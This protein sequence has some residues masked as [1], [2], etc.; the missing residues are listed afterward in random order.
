MTR[1]VDVLIIGAGLSGIGMA[2]HLTREQ[3]GRSY[4]ILERRTAIGGTWDL[5]R[6]PGIRSDSDMYTFG[7]GFR[8][9]IGTKVLADGPH[10]RQYIEDTA[11]E[12]GVTDHI[13]FGRKVTTARWSTE[14]G[15]WTVEALDEQT[16]GIEVYTS[17]FLVGCTGYYDYD[18]GYRPEFRG[19]ADFGG[20]IVHPQHWP[21]D[22]DY[23]GKRVVVIGSGATAIT[24]IPA[25]SDDTAHVTML[26]RSPTYITALPVDDPVAVGMKLTRVPAK[27][28]YKLG[29]ARNIALQRASFQ[30]SRTNPEM[31]KKLLL[32]AVRMQV[33]KDIDMRHFTPS[34]NPWDQR[35]CVVP[36]GD[37]FKVLRSG[38]A[39]IVTDR[40]ETFTETGIRLE[41]GAELPADI[42]IS[43]TG[44]TVQMLG[45][46]TLEVDGEP[47]VTRDR[48]AYKGALLSGIPNAMVVLGYTNASWTLKADLAAEYF[49]RLLNHMKANGF[50]QVVA[51]AQ[52]GDRAEDSLMGGA[53]TSGYIQRGD[54]VM[55]RQ[56]TRG[57]WKVINNYFR[58][59]TLLRKGPI[60]DGVLTF[61]TPNAATRPGQRPVADSR[62]A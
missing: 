4:A 12:Y 17:N 11:A 57:P 45:G 8:P 49:C 1:H 42:V 9:W 5:F 56:G 59:R 53:L 3:T 27:V 46:A 51:V 28:A 34:Y 19:E 29:R 14:S 23:Q 32:G 7:Y 6:Y 2:C 50:D 52:D 55:P 61:T 36:N 38:R 62:I 18:N 44:L 13:R 16:G 37:L 24:L 41:S 22:L 31:A 15:L 39:S 30:L 21:A 48:V 58:D 35:L 20:Q 60:E 47:V 54:A 40:I 25:M 43:A 26:Q 10:I 33:G